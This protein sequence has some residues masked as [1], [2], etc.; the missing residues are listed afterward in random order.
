MGLQQ[1][2]RPNLGVAMDFR[3]IELAEW[4]YQWLL[5]IGG[6]IG[7]DYGFVTGSFS[8]SM[9]IFGGFCA[10]ACL[11]CI[12]DFDFYNKHAYKWLSPLNDNQKS[13]DWREDFGDLQQARTNAGRKTANKK[14][15]S[16][17]SGA[18]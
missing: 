4:I 14:Q 5:V 11:I 2:Y 16:R 8:S 3:G 18:R 7:W 1:N 17:R 13:Y 12:Y 6:V 10:L 15:S 9:A